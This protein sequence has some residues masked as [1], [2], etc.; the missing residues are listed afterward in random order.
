V[1]NLLSDEHY[2]DRHCTEQ[3]EATTIAARTSASRPAARCQ[4][5]TITPEVAVI[6]TKQ[7]KID[8]YIDE[9]DAVTRAEVRLHNRDKTGLV[10][11]GTAR[12]HPDDAVIPEIGDELAVA[13]ALAD[14]THQLMDASSMDIEAIMHQP[15]RLNGWPA[16]ATA[17][18]P[19]VPRLPSVMARGCGHFDSVLIGRHYER[20]ADHAVSVA[21]RVAFLAGR[22]TLD[23]YRQPE[24]H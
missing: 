6:H 7:W 13:R 17:S 5:R 14:L 10:G 16:G 18:G 21:H 4:P 2:P 11:V 20:F 15:V 22:G 23:C 3:E 24:A 19:D 8:V 12:C 9:H 1:L